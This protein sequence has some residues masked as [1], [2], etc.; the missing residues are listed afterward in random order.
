MRI[1]EREKDVLYSSVMAIDPMARI[2]LFGSRVAEQ[3]K[4]GDIDLAILSTKIGRAELRRIRRSILDAI[5]E[6]HLD[7]VASQNGS[8]AFFRLAVEGGVEINA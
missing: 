6:Q 8:E 2:W 4:G 7:L 5:G 1:T 3:K